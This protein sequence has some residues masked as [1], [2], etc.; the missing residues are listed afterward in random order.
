MSKKHDEVTSRIHSAALTVV[1]ALRH[2]QLTIGDCEAVIAMA[3][4]LIKCAP[5]GESLNMQELEKTTSGHV[6]EE[7]VRLLSQRDH[8]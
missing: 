2:E 4:M 8:N 5:F 6:A 1:A 7:M 3:G